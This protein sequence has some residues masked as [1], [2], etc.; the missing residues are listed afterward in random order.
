MTTEGR[1]V[2]PLSD[3]CTTAMTSGN[4]LKILKGSHS[5]FSL[6]GLTVIKPNHPLASQLIANN[7]PAISG[8]RI[9][10]SS[11]LLVNYLST[12]TFSPEQ[13]VLELGCGWGLASTYVKKH[14]E[15][16]VTAS[17]GDH[18]VLAFQNL[19]SDANDVSVKF[20]HLSF[21]ELA[22]RD[23]SHINILIGSDICYSPSITRDLEHLF[24]R[25]ANQGGS[26]II[27]ADR[28][29][30][31]FIGMIERLARHLPLQVIDHNIE[32]PAKIQGKILHIRLKT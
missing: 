29:R 4:T 9:W 11:Y 28:G 3:H 16:K 18:Q 20:K 6:K 23:L 13:H 24:H 5:S 2:S 8:S 12:Q 1:Y 14:F 21:V 30:P 7:N 17:D 25:F 22:E 26:E 15:S 10:P 19:L 32:L 31:S 27:L